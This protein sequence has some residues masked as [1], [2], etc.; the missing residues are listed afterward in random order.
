MERIQADGEH[1]GDRLL[2]EAGPEGARSQEQRVEEFRENVLART[3][4]G[5]TASCH[6]GTQGGDN[7]GELE[8]LV[9]DW[10]GGLSVWDRNGDSPGAGGTRAEGSKAGTP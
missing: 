9:R 7:P 5:D 1:K 10:E 4:L 3:M 6:C 8:L 2:E